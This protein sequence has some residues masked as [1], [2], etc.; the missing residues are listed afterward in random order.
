[1]TSKNLDDFLATQNSRIHNSDRK[2]ANLV[3]EAYPIGVPALIMKSS[4]DRMVDSSGY[5]FILG[6]PDE[7]LRHLA[8]WLITN[9]GNTHRILLKLI[10]RLWKRHGREDVALSAILLS[11]LDHKGM[12]TNP[13]EILQRSIHSIEP[14]D[15]L[16]LNIEELF[17]A[18]RQPPKESQILDWINGEK[19]EQ[20]MSLIVIYSATIHGHKFSTDLI[21]AILRINI[22]DGDSILT[23]IKGKIASLE[24]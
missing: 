20:H 10:D 24:A 4:T 7:L 14:L 15:S 16:L 18:K 11:N 19:I 2:L 22:P 12:K 1:M 5:A 21:N 9:A 6:T 8:S 13:W 23:R 3:R 17:R